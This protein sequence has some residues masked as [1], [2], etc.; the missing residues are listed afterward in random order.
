MSQ[1]PRRCSGMRPLMKPARSATVPV[2]AELSARYTR[3][4]G[5]HWWVDG[6]GGSLGPPRDRIIA[7][8]GVDAQ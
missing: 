6:V 8:I 1:P 5:P 3:C 4:A 2:A 7:A